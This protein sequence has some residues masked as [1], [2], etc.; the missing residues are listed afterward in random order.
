MISNKEIYD[1][2][3]QSLV[4][5]NEVQKKVLAIKEEVS[6]FMLSSFVYCL[7]SILVSGHI[8]RGIMFLYFNL[9]ENNLFLVIYEKL[10][11][12]C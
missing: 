12:S 8:E 11:Y 1:L 2:L 4:P 9:L 7:F 5:D 3:Q 10:Q 6:S